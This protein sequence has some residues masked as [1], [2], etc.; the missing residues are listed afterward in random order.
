MNPDSNNSNYD[1][2]EEIDNT[3]YRALDKLNIKFAEAEML[4][5][6]LDNLKECNKD[7]AAE[8]REHKRR[9]KSM[10]RTALIRE[11]LN[12][13]LTENLKKLKE[14]HD[15]MIANKNKSLEEI[16][17]EFVSELVL[18]NWV[19][20]RSQQAQPPPQPPVPPSTSDQP[21]TEQPGPKSSD[22]DPKN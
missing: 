21:P 22:S 7:L 15:R 8:T 19:Y 16:T 2:D 3:I 17:S 4:Q 12:K 14:S 1:S 6:I 13:L 11:Q 5:I 20:S 10:N 18:L 9:I